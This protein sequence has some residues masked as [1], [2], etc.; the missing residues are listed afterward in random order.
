M[1][2][3]RRFYDL[4]LEEKFAASRASIEKL[5][6]GHGKELKNPVFCGWRQVQVERRLVDHELRRRDERV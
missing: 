1:S 2:R 3:A 5:H 6:P 4:S